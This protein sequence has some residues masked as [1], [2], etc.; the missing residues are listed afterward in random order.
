M[1]Q[2]K[3]NIVGLLELHVHFYYMLIDQV[4]GDVIFTIGYLNKMSSSVL[5]NNV[6]Q[7]LCLS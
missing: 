1:T 3:E 6:C 5:N 4:L 2:H 7:V